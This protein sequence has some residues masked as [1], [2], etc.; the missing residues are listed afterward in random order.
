MVDPCSGIRS[1]FALTMIAALYAYFAVKPM[2][3]QFIV[4]ACAIPLAILGNLLRILMLTFGTIAFGTEF[5]IGKDA[6]EE[7]LM[8]SHGR[9]IRCFHRC[10][11]RTASYWLPHSSGLE[12]GVGRSKSSNNPP[13]RPLAVGPDDVY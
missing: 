8:V 5:A 3:K 10:A 11:R 7:L 9:W 6:L 4:F 1:L 12:K 2:W 13:T